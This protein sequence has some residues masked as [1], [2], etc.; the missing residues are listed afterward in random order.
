MATACLDSVEDNCVVIKHKHKMKEG[1]LDIRVCALHVYQDPGIKLGDK[2]RVAATVRQAKLLGA[3]NDKGRAC[4][5]SQLAFRVSE[6]AALQTRIP[7]E[8]K[9]PRGGVAFPF[10]CVLF[11]YCCSSNPNLLVIN[12]F[13]A[14]RYTYSAR[15]ISGYCLSNCSTCF[16][17]FS[18]TD[19]A[20]D[21]RC[22]CMLER[23][24]SKECQKTD[25]KGGHKLI[26]EMIMESNHDSYEF[27]QAH[28][29]GEH[30][31]L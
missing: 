20:L 30:F 24:C 29:D 27:D 31:N 10:P 13:V 14:F 17:R 7:Q 2:L 28:A 11:G 23:Y 16:V 4:L 22:P 26:H 1:D 12:R 9:N 5:H 25:W 21:S 3:R 8:F 15:F 19:D 18:S 6:Y